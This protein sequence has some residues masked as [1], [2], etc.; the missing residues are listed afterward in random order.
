MVYAGAFGYRRLRSESA[1]SGISKMKKTL[2]ELK[3]IVAMDL[4]SPFDAAVI[5]GSG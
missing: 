1:P 4:A 2:V 5:C 3:A